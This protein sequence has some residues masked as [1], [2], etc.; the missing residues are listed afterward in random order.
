MDSNDPV[1][2]IVAANISNDLQ[3]LLKLII[4]KMLLWR[5][6]KV[7]VMLTKTPPVQ[8]GCP[9]T[10]L[11]CINPMMKSLQQ[12]YF[13]FCTMYNV[14]VVKVIISLDQKIEENIDSLVDLG[15]EL[16]E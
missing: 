16:L 4:L 3:A 9:N 2:K 1:A 8:V 12:S 7:K 6:K 15:D 5:R 10:P 13:I 14:R 11:S